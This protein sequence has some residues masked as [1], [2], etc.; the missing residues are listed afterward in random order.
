MDLKRKNLLRFSSEF[1]STGNWNER[2]TDTIIE[3]EN[4]GWSSGSS[5]GCWLIV[6]IGFYSLR[7][8]KEKIQIKEVRNWGE[9]R[10]E[11]R[12]VQLSRW[13]LK[14]ML[15]HWVFILG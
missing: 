13:I 14:I 8:D 2:L 6:N 15:V 3:V 9:G 10:K 12:L 4:L 11:F 7:S 1:Y 5:S